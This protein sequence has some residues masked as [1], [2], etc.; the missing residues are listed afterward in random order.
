[1]SNHKVVVKLQ[2]FFFSK[3]FKLR[4][5]NEADVAL[6]I[7]ATNMYIFDNPT[8]FYIFPYKEMISSEPQ[9]CTKA[10]ATRASISN[11]HRKFPLFSIHHYDIWYIQ[12]SIGGANCWQTIGIFNYNYLPSL[13][14]A[15][16]PIVWLKM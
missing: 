15:Q 4:S 11:P 10:K 1:M 16:V 2:T 9:K 5:P 12:R 14:R 7:L 8:L 3:P 6:K 13:C